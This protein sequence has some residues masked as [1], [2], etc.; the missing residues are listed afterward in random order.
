MLNEFFGGLDFGSSGSRLSLINQKKE[1]KYSKSVTYEYGFKNPNSWIFSCEKLLDSLPL[2]VRSN[3][4]SLAISGTSGT[5]IACNSKGE[6]L[7]E[8]IPYNQICN[9][10]KNLIK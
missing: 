10:N 3:I 4:V 2:D 7:G 5:L 8:A 6:S 1:L 9:E